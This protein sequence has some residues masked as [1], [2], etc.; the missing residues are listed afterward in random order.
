MSDVSLK[1]VVKVADE[2]LR[3][4]EVP[5]YSQAHNGLQL[6]NSGGVRRLVAAVDAC[7]AVLLRAAAERGTLL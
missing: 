3:I 4:L 1:D 5:D 2:W 6:D 7:E